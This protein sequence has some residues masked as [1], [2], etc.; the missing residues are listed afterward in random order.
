METSL[1]TFLAQSP[2]LQTI[3][4]KKSTLLN[5]ADTL[6]P[7]EGADLEALTRIQI[8][9]SDVF[10]EEM[11]KLIQEEQEAK[12]A[13]IQSWGERERQDVTHELGEV[14]TTALCELLATKVRANQA[15]LQRF[16]NFQ[17]LAQEATQMAGKAQALIDEGNQDTL[18]EFQE[19]FNALGA[20]VLE[21][22]NWIVLHPPLENDQAVIA[23]FKEE[24]PSS[25]CLEGALS[26][27]H[28]RY[29]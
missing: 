26:L 6:K 22:R 4:L 8:K 5:E 19:K 12:L 15:A 25:Q 2:A 23:A 11:P 17:L 7:Q 13:A 28:S 21:E 29:H 9:I 20:L 1:S 3:A 16:A 24:H 14:E 27:Y 18:Q 10:A